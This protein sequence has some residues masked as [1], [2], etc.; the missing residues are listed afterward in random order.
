MVND[1]VL[2]FAGDR[3]PTISFNKNDNP[4]YELPCAQDQP[5]ECGTYTGVA[6]EE[7]GVRRGL[8]TSGE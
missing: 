6:F 5:G 1:L 8:V 4:G 2:T 3:F 7:T